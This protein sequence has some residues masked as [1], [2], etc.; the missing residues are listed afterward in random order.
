MEKTDCYYY[1][2][3][4]GC[5]KKGLPE[6]RCEI[7]GCVCYTKTNPLYQQCLSEVDPEV[8]AEVRAIMEK[9]N[10]QI[11]LTVLKCA[12]C[13][14]FISTEEM[15]TWCS[16]CGSHKFLEIHPRSIVQDFFQSAQHLAERVDQYLV[17]GCKRSELKAANDALKKLLK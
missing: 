15:L 1:N 3:L 7:E 9:V 11:P 12:N 14:K 5:C 2:N 6:T 13:G 10:P 8:R 17:Q 4:T 16:S